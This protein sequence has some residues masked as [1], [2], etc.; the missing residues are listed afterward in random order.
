MVPALAFFDDF[1]AFLHNKFLF[2][3]ASMLHLDNEP[4]IGEPPIEE[5]VEEGDSGP[6]LEE[7]EQQ[8]ER[9]IEEE[10]NEPVESEVIVRG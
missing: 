1:Y 9:E 6:D 2:I 4:P 7:G 10:T 3:C 8:Q 5:G